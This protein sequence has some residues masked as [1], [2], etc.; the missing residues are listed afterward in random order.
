MQLRHKNQLPPQIER[1]VGS[2]QEMR[3]KLDKSCRTLTTAHSLTSEYYSPK[4]FQAYFLAIAKEAVDQASTQ[5]D[6]LLQEISQQRDALQAEADSIETP[7][8]QYQELYEQID[9]INKNFI[10][11]MQAAAHDFFLKVQEEL[12]CARD[13]K[14]ALASILPIVEIFS[15][16]ALIRYDENEQDFEFIPRIKKEEFN[17]NHPAW[18]SFEEKLKKMSQVLSGIQSSGMKKAIEEKI[19]MAVSIINGKLKDN[20]TVIENGFTRSIKVSTTTAE[21]ITKA[22]QL[23][24]QCADLVD[25]YKTDTFVSVPA[26]ELSQEQQTLLTKKRKTDKL[27]ERSQATAHC[28]YVAHEDLEDKSEAEHKS[29]ELTVDAFT[30]DVVAASS[31]LNQATTRLMRDYKHPDFAVRHQAYQ[32]FQHVHDAARSINVG[33]KKTQTFNKIITL[34]HTYSAKKTTELE[35]ETAQ[36]FTTCEQ[37]L[38][39]VLAKADKFVQA[40]KADLLRIEQEK[41]QQEVLDL[42]TLAILFNLTFWNNQVFGKSCLFSGFSSSKVNG[43]KVPSGIKLITDILGSKLSAL[44]KVTRIIQLLDQKKNE[45]P[46]RFCFFKVRSDATSNLYQAGDCFKQ[47]GNLTQQQVDQFKKSLGNIQDGSGRLRI[48]R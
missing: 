27:V 15:N 30:A 16:Y 20:F 11:L 17:L 31:D 37:A 41:L 42:F 4:K 5:P 46:T 7:F 18:R 8:V 21:K 14:A 40:N 34:Q 22:G 28:L 35:R 47:P 39:P 25:K 12:R 13:K 26:K 2:L 9:S 48:P 33:R 38:V 1:V 19:N 3:D 10:A 36:K 29:L 6:I 32:D 44:D 23:I 43:V 24:G 45:S